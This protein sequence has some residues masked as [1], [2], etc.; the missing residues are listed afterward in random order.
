MSRS[1][2]RR[3]LVVILA[4]AVF[5]L[6]LARLTARF[7]G[8]TLVKEVLA[9]LQGGVMSLWRGVASAFQYVGNARQIKQENE[10]LQE[11]VRELTW[12]NNR[13]REYVY[14][15]KRLLKLLD[16][17]E[18]N[19]SRFTLLGARV[20]ARVPNNQYGILTV[21]RGSADGVRKDQVVVS[22]AGLV[23]RIIAVGPHTSD[24]L[25]ILDRDGAAGAMVQESRTPGVV[26]GGKDESGLLRMVDLPY[27]AR[28]KKGDV[29]VT[30]GLG[31]IFPRGIPIGEIVRFENQ[32][33]ALDKY[34]LV[35][36]YV[37]FNRL[38]EV[39]IITGVREV[40][41]PVEGPAGSNQAEA[42]R[43][44]QNAAPAGQTGRNAG[45]TR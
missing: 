28:L 30:S 44:G 35:R 6:G 39:L 40:P 18:K 38:E 13:L 2:W 17:K 12:E 5:C 3:K 41:E 31:G 15:N 42:G 23:G 21:D 43:A 8:G 45:R 33:S 7:S 9:P 14:E 16:F 36:P 20:I 11:R 26:E 22:D 10:R 25:L 32:G 4:I 34:A 24:V 19:A 27:D 1:P 37:D 29:V